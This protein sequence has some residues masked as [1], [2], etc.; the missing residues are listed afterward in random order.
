MTAAADHAAVNAALGRVACRC[1]NAD[2]QNVGM[3]V[4]SAQADPKLS[5]ERPTPTTRS[6]AASAELDIQGTLGQSVCS[7]GPRDYFSSSFNSQR[8]ADNK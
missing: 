2:F 8:T 7:M 6:L 3:I 1:A 4:M 5:R